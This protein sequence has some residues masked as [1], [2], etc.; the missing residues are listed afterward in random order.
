[1][2][3]IDIWNEQ[4]DSY[5]QF[6]VFLMLKS[7][8]QKKYKIT[9]PCKNFEYTYYEDEETVYLEFSNEVSVELRK[10]G[11]NTRIYKKNN[12]NLFE[13]SISKKESNEFFEKNINHYL[14]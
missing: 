14:I 1:M 7:I 9:I 12:T 5:I 11:L 3:P 6:L 13:A 10:L 8:N 2:K 4:K